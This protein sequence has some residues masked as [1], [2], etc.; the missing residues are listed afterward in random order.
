MFSRPRLC[1]WLKQLL[2][3]TQFRHRLP[4]QTY[5][6]TP[7]EDSHFYYVARMLVVSRAGRGAQVL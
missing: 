6:R 7:L 5:W 2:A 3:Y 4:S 1:A